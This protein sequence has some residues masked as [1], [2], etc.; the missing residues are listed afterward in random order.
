MTPSEAIYGRPPPT[1]PTYVLGAS[2]NEVVNIEL[3]SCD[4]ILQQQG[5][6]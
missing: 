6:S 5:Q 3:G 4:L 1:I 2:H